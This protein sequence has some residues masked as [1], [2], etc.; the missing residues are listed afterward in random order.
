MPSP[1][2]K[3]GQRRNT[4]S[5]SGRKARSETSTSHKGS[6]VEPSH[7]VELKRATREKKAAATKK[8][9]TKR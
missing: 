7:I 4:T 3:I 6:R 2:K 5:A 8:R 1:K 9:S